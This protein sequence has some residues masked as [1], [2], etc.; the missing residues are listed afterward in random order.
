MTYLLLVSA[1]ELTPDSL[2]IV[3][4]MPESSD[5]WQGVEKQASGRQPLS[6]KKS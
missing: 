1:F 6:Q 4:K 3:S 2:Q 5:A